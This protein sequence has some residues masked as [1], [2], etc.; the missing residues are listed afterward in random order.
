M[1]FIISVIDWANL[2]QNAYF[3]IFENQIKVDHFRLRQIPAFA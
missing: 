1:V 3:A 2:F